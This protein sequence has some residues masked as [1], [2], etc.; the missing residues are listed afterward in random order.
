MTTTFKFCLLPHKLYSMYAKLTRPKLIWTCILF[1]SLSHPQSI[2]A[3]RQGLTLHISIYCF[4]K[5][6]KPSLSNGLLCG[7][8]D[9]VWVSKYF[10]VNSCI[11]TPTSFIYLC[12][13]WVPWLDYFGIN[14]LDYLYS[15]HNPL[16]SRPRVDW[17]IS[18]LIY[19]VIRQIV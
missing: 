5:L 16:I 18:A 12:L 9:F 8:S 4:C 14:Y 15:R 11:L 10:S 6:I 1:P 17:Q 19:N 2:Y 3:T 13:M 7:M